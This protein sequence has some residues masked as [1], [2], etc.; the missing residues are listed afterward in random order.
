[1]TINFRP[2][3]VSPRAIIC[4]SF[5]SD[6]KKANLVSDLLETYECKFFIR[7]KT[8]TS[9]SIEVCTNTPARYTNMG[10]GYIPKGSEKFKFLERWESTCAGSLS[11]QR[12]YFK[13]SKTQG[14]EELLEHISNVL[15]DLVG[16][17]A[18]GD[19]TIDCELRFF[20]TEGLV[21]FPDNLFV[22]HEDK[23][24]NLI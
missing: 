12:F 22:F 2:V 9:L 6:L 1:M 10:V 21:I 11:K 3:Q 17:K 23:N 20:Q 24:G 13:I 15:W 18:I 8:K 7:P 14:Y 16:D 19:Q 5:G 4:D